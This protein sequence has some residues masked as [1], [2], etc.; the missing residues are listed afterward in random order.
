MPLFVDVKK[1]TMFGLIF[2][3]VAGIMVRLYSPSLR[4]P[5]GSSEPRTA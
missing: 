4:E 5:E 2:A 3:S 1:N